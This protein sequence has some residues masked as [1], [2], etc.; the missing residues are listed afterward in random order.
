[1][2]LLY[3]AHRYYPFP[4]GTENYV[5]A[6]AEESLSRGHDVTVFAGEHKGNQNGVKVTDDPQQLLQPYDLIIVHGGNVGVQNFV[7]SNAP[8]IPS[9]IL[10]IIVAPSD[11]P[12]YLNA[13]REC[14]YVSWSTPQD[15]DYLTQQGVLGKTFNVRHGITPASCIGQSG[16]FRDKFG[17]PKDKK[18]F[19]SCGGYWQNKLMRELVEVFK[20]A[21][22]ED[23][24]LVTTG[25]DNRFGIMPEAATN[26][27]P[28]MI[29]D[30]E[31]VMNAIADADCYVMHSNFEGFGLVLLESMLN[32]TPW[33]SRDLA[34]ATLMKQ[35][36]ATYNTDDELIDLLRNFNRD[37]AKIASAYDY[38]TNN[39]LIKNTVDDIEAVL[40]SK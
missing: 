21:N 26:I 10:F 16:V 13:M 8:N 39:H 30:K 34:G 14:A 19:L 2:K 32:H 7:L 35:H 5:R 22:V 23:A 1:M 12:V 38:V 18:M 31:D 33:I 36:G 40:N 24:V 11:T 27:Y 17:I 25:Y 3:V 20:K 37:D 9:P 28:L 6:M 15:L 4:G 29:D